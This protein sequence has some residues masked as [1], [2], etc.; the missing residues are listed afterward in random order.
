M[1]AV[2]PIR[3]TPELRTWAWVVS[4][5]AQR[6][7]KDDPRLRSMLFDDVTSKLR[8]ICAEF[9]YWFMTVEPGS[10]VVGGFPY[11]IAPTAPL[12]LGWLDRGW[13]ITTVGQE[14]YPLMAQVDLSEDM[15]LLA[16]C[17]AKEMNYVKRFSLSGAMEADLAIATSDK[18]YSW[19]CNQGV[20]NTGML[21]GAPYMVYPDTNHGATTLCLNPVPDSAYIMCCSWDLATPP[22]FTYRECVTNLILQYY[23]G[24]IE[25]LVGIAYAE[26]FKESDLLTYYDMK[27]FGEEM[28][29]V[30][31]GIK[32]HGIIGTMRNDTNS[33]FSQETQELEWFQSAR[34]AVGRGGAWA[35]RPGDSY[36]ISPNDYT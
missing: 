3:P 7:G 27:L 4:K 25:C 13:F 1:A 28:G 12:T 5:V 18:Y 15:T 14:R 36:Y 2:L 16:P 23:P 33:R 22:W 6:F 20:A 17:E 34:A 31:S 9:P 10:Q 29:R 30:R 19:G 21:S 32:K 35:R 24:V 11:I 26:F 8:E